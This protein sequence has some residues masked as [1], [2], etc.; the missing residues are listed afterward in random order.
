MRRLADLQERSPDDPSQQERAVSDAMGDAH[1]SLSDLAELLQAG[2]DRARRAADEAGD[3]PADEDGSDLLLKDVEEVGALVT[4]AQAAFEALREKAKEVARLARHPEPP[5]ESSTRRGRVLGMRRLGDLME[6]SASAKRPTADPK[7]MKDAL[8]VADL[9][10]ETWDALGLQGTPSGDEEVAAR[11]LFLKKME[12]AFGAP[13]G[14]IPVE[15]YY[16]LEDANYHTANEILD[17]VRYF[18]APYGE[19]QD[20]W[21]RERQGIKPMWER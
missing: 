11:V 21:E 6:R 12:K 4:E 16:E 13:H 9:H 10:A 15:V 1:A 8:K 18:D 7:W 2:A 14:Q 19:R 17:K 3:L 5:E 20:S